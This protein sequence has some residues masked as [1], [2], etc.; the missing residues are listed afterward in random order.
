MKL[1]LIENVSEYYVAVF[2]AVED[3]VIVVVTP[4]RSVDVVSIGIKGFGGNS[5]KFMN[6]LAIKESFI[7]DL[8]S[9]TIASYVIDNNGKAP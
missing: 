8:T 6:L 4:G 3:G 9:L 1:N 7:V 2:A 5:C